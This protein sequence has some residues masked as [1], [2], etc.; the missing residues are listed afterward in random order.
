MLLK[1]RFILFSTPQH[2][3]A[4]YIFRDLT[5]QTA[6][7]NWKCSFDL[8]E[9]SLSKK[10]RAEEKFQPRE[11]SRSLLDETSPRSQEQVQSPQLDLLQH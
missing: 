9:I 10:M 1:N 2:N 8:K 7:C 4:N 6:D 5:E 3:Y 11:T